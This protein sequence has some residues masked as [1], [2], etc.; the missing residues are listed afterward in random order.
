MMNL[1]DDWQWHSSLLTTVIYS[2]LKWFLFQNIHKTI[3][4]EYNQWCLKV[5][6]NSTS[7]FLFSSEESVT[8]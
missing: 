4:R 7:L 2:Q 3:F 5:K 1:T 6:V 8:F